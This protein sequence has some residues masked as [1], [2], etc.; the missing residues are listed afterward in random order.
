[1]LDEDQVRTA[2]AAVLPR[3]GEEDPWDGLDPVEAG[4]DYLRRLLDGGWAVPTWP[5]EYGGRGASA[6]EA[7]L[8]DRVRAEFHQPGLYP[9]GVGMALV[10]PVLMRFGTREQRDRWCLAIASGEQ[11]WCQL[12][13]EPEAGS[14][15]AGL[16]TRA[17]LDGD[18]WSFHGQKVWTSRA[19]S[20][21]M[22]FCL[23]RTDVKAPK[24]RGLSMFALPMRQD[25]VTVRP[26][27]QMNGDAHFNEV[28]LDGCTAGAMSLIG[29]REAGWSVAL[30]AL[31]FERSTTV[32]RE[33]APD[34]IAVP[35]WLA[36]LHSSGALED[37]VVLDDAMRAFTM[38]ATAALADIRAAD[39][40]TAGAPGAEG[41]AGKIR[42]SASYKAVAG[43]AFGAQHLDGLLAGSDA[44]RLLLTAP[45]MS[46]R[47]GTDE[48][49]RNIIGERVLGLPK[50]P[51]RDTDI[52]WDQRRT[53]RPK[54]A[55]A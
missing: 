50:D 37:P 38:S 9:F 43:A 12:F 1:M 33:V 29:E 11:L 25:G 39:M 53:S 28:F 3:R 26:L 45:S 41:S 24:H 47:G 10:G 32:I 19:L 46:I 27:R 30:T 44:A 18:T 31:S 35:D 16:A 48:I 15:I 36:K 21:D 55:S 34:P 22:G 20:A 8:I 17:T 7:A 5:R 51:F 42:H 14:D 49:Q 40:R 23:A 4:R 2:L 52:P 54:G 13:S 6:G